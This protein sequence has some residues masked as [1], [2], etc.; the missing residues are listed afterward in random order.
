MRTK[1]TVSKVLKENQNELGGLRNAG[2]H[3]SERDK[4]DAF[5]EGPP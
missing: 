5:I 3:V 1:Q 4:K 2:L